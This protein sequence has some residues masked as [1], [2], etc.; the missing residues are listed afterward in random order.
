MHSLQLSWWKGYHPGA[1][2]LRTCY[3]VTRNPGWGVGE[4]CFLQSRT[5]I[6][7][8]SGLR[9]YARAHG[10]KSSP[11]TAELLRRW[12]IHTQQRPKTGIRYFVYRNFASKRL[13]KK[14]RASV[15]S[16]ENTPQQ[17]SQPKKLIH[18]ELTFCI[19]VDSS[20]ACSKMDSN[21][22]KLEI[23]I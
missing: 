16:L 18:E 14:I 1:Q 21:S 6:H 15:G 10:R 2:N 17:P 23:G 9:M 8:W 22:V 12:S 13:K 5:Q 11:N 20:T 4:H 19:N 7:C 3:L